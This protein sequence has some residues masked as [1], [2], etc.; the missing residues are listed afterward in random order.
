VL[1]SD[2]A[3]KTVNKSWRRRPDTL[4]VVGPPGVIDLRSESC[5][6]LDSAVRA[7]LTEANDGNDTYDEDPS[8]HALEEF[9]AD[10][11]GMRQAVFVPT[12]RM[13]NIIATSVLCPPDGEVL[14]DAWAHMLKAEYGST[15]GLLG[16]QTRT[17]ASRGGRLD[18]EAVLSLVRTSHTTRPTKLVCVEDPHVGAGGVPQQLAELQRLTSELR[19]LGIA[20]YCDGA[21]L[22]Y[23][24][25]DDRT[26]WSTY[27]SLYDGLTVSLVKGPGAPVGAIVLFRDERRDDAIEVRRALGG[28]W[29]RPGALASAALVAL[30]ARL[31][32]FCE[33]CARAEELASLLAE[34][35]GAEAVSHHIN[36]MEIRI[37][38][39]LV[40]FERCKE[41]GV[42]LF[43]PEQH[44][45]R[46][47]IHQGI[48]GHA[49]DLAAK[50]IIRAASS[51]SDA[52]EQAHES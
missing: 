16:R 15:N 41:L 31:G 20:S 14:L 9:V 32:R 7:A 44:R 8:V 29:A 42:L 40:F 49:V 33:D 22:W 18:P 21:R 4:P 2:Q 13:A 47:V 50:V 1:V 12:G 36:M 30:R 24:N 43:R 25:A 48:D 38:D 19:R 37:P 6:P 10:L 17:Y 27:G 39:S 3:K 46:A 23:V 35:L 51:F 45:V 28:G 52:E 34:Q 11:F 26:A 5:A